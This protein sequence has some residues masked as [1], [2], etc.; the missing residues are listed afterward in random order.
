[1][2]KSRS[3][4]VVCSISLSCIA[5]KYCHIIRG[6]L[7]SVYIIDF[8]IHTLADR[9]TMTCKVIKFLVRYIPCEHVLLMRC[10][11]APHR[12]G[13]CSSHL[14][15]RPQ[16]M[17][18]G[19]NDMYIDY[20]KGLLIKK[21]GYVLTSRVKFTLDYVSEE[22]ASK[23]FKQIVAETVISIYIYNNAKEQ[24]S[25]LFPVGT[26]NL[27]L[28]YCGQE[29]SEDRFMK[30]CWRS[31]INTIN[32]TYNA[33][34]VQYIIKLIFPIYIKMFPRFY[35]S[36]KPIAEHTIKLMEKFQMSDMFKNDDFFIH[37]IGKCAYEQAK[38]VKAPIV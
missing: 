18:R 4:F 33:Y 1:M 36:N 13:I 34:K 19:S 29:Y 23:T 35:I 7:K 8:I 15:N 5:V 21:V 27:I 30:A 22:L 38:R 28:D 17:Y 9:N 10:Q 32:T 31:L 26:M 2:R 3:R 12:D 6:D 25:V 24:L 14:F 11:N 16:L 20:G 37:Y